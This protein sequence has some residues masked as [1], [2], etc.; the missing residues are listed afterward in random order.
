[1]VL[2]REYRKR[3]GKPLVILAHQNPLIN[4]ITLSGH[5]F[6]ECLLLHRVRCNTFIDSKAIVHSI[7][8][9]LFFTS[10]IFPCG[11]KSI[12]P[13]VEYGYKLCIMDLGWSTCLCTSTDVTLEPDI[14]TTKFC[15]DIS[16][17]IRATSYCFLFTVFTEGTESIILNKPTL[18]IFMIT[19]KNCSCTCSDL[20]K[21]HSCKQISLALKVMGLVSKAV[22]I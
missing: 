14:W 13:T 3:H 16:W 18:Y 17:V 10:M 6:L 2:P 22:L 19:E 15:L 1:M 12:H 11:Y 7:H 8:S 5:V 4:I 20:Y 21:V 9:I